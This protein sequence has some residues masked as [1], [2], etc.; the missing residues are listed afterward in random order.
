MVQL[1]AQL[2]EALLGK[3]YRLLLHGFHLLLPASAGVTS[4]ARA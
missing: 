3:E 1:L 2:L 4:E